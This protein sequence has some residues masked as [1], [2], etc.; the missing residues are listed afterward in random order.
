M[1]ITSFHPINTAL[2]TSLARGYTILRTLKDQKH[3]APLEESDLPM[4]ARSLENQA[5]KIVPAPVRSLTPKADQY[6][7]LKAAYTSQL[8]GHTPKTNPTHPI[9]SDANG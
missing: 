6:A 1:W 7:A 9:Q 5:T 2:D 3:L 4:E 8:L